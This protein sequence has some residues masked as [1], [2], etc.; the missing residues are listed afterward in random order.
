MFDKYI[1]NAPPRLR[2]MGEFPSEEAPD[3]HLD[4]P[5]YEITNSFF[6][7]RLSIQ[8]RINTTD[9]SVLTKLV[10]SFHYLSFI[11]F[12]R[13]YFFF[14]QFALISISVLLVRETKRIMI[15]ELTSMTVHKYFDF[16]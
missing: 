13:D 1:R 14:N 10:P 11:F 3:P 6:I 9:T 8:P 12:N 5:R 16:S 7:S 2:P 4:Q 15:I